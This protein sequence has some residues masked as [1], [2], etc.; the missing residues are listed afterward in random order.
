MKGLWIPALLAV[1]AMVITVVPC[2]SDG[3]DNEGTSVAYD[4]TTYK[5]LRFSVPTY[6]CEMTDFD[7]GT[8]TFLRVQ[9]RLEGYPVYKMDDGVLS[10]SSKVKTFVIPAEVQIMGSGMFSGCSALKEIIF[11][12]AM[13]Q[14]AEDAF[15]GVPSGTVVKYLERYSS[16][17]S[18]FTAL[19]KEVLPVYKYEGSRCSYEYCELDGSV[20]VLRHLKG[21][22]ITIPSKLKVGSKD[23]DVKYI[24]DSAFFYDEKSEQ[25]KIT[26]VTI[27]EGIVQIGVAAFK[28]CEF[29]ESV[30]LPSSLK[31]IYDEA[32][33]MPIDTENWSR[34]KL[35][36]ISLPNGLEYLGFEAFRMNYSLKTVTV[37]D[38]VTHYG[39]GAFRVCA[40]METITLGK[41]VTELGDSS[42]DNCLSLKTVN[43]PATLTSIGNECF[44][45]DRSLVSIDIPAAVTS[46]GRN[47]FNGC[48]NL[49][50]IN[51]PDGATLGDNCFSATSLITVGITSG[52]G[53]GIIKKYMSD[54]GWV[55]PGM[56]QGTKVSLLVIDTADSISVGVTGTVSGFMRLTDKSVNTTGGTLKDGA[57]TLSGAARA[58]KTYGYSG[59]VWSTAEAATVT[60]LSSDTTLGTVSPRGGTFAVG[61][62]TTFTAEPKPYCKFTGWSD[63]DKNATR[64]MTVTKDQQLT[65]TFA[66]AETKIISI[67]IDPAGSGTYKGAGKF[68]VGTTA[69][70]SVASTGDYHLIG[71]NDGYTELTRSVTVTEDISYV[72]SFGN[73]M[74]TFDTNGG[75]IPI[76]PLYSNDGWK[77]TLPSSAEVKDGKKIVSWTIDGTKYAVGSEYEV[78][79]PVTATAVWGTNDGGSGGFPWIWVAAAAV[80]AIAAVIA[81][82]FL[83]SRNR[84]D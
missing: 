52:S 11:L 15:S 65:A 50:Q 58:G 55:L 62:A 43:M 21:T 5:Y 3:A 60:V 47:A 32:F 18:S 10:G 33:R 72:V 38:S 8:D 19:T 16:S 23:V 84:E 69:N 24:G 17:W 1:A 68:I 34:G 74:I 81:W 2:E 77:M 42:F 66:K 59:G 25:D 53:T 39:D 56:A 48:T 4:G 51:L 9:S 61:T 37:P 79:G 36:S 26:K 73:I 31:I 27:Q 63:G 83:S 71:W 28:Y 20:T 70:L 35:Q 64:M 76:G 75:A 13:P 41:G 46:I 12:G 82:R 67:T 6:Q 57:S 78:H 7:A 80:V 44:Q 45:G 54:G 30:S 40:G 29:L 14:F 49:S 22:E